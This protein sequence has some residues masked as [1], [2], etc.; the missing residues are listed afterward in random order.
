MAPVPI[1][2]PLSRSRRRLY[3]GGLLLIFILSVPLLFLYATGY[4]FEGITGLVKTGGMY[5]GAERSAA[6]IYINGELVR[7]T[8]TFKRA[9]FV[10]DLEPGTY[11]VNIVKDGYHPWGKTLSVYPHIVTEAQAFNMPEEPLLTRI[12][13]SIAG[14]T[15]GTTTPLTVPN[16]VYETIMQSFATT[17]ATSTIAVVPPRSM[18]TST[19]QDDAASRV[20][21][22][23]TKEFRGMLLVDAGDAVEAR[24]TRG[25]EQIPFYFCVP[26]QPCVLEIPLNTKD[27]KPSY[28]DFFPGTYDLVI[29]TLPDGVYVTELDNRSG[30]NIQPLFLADGADFRLVDG[31]IY[32]LADERLYE[33]EI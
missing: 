13:E 4:R 5:I 26:E 8:G 32:V 14:S 12:P 16:P 2:L 29:V 10:Q 25:T 24:W 18:S 15:T 23:T 31:N 19:F 17:T 20:V 3:F 21:A 28:F 6:E 22:T 7:E 30:Q 11:T 27:D 1:I 33:V 9:F